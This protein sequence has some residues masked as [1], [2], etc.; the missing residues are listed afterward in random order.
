M[1]ASGSTI[2]VILPAFSFLQAATTLTNAL[3]QDEVSMGTTILAVR[4]KD[5]IVVGADTRTSVSGYVSNRYAAKLTFVLDGDVDNFVAPFRRS[6]SPSQPP[7][8]STTT[9]AKGVD[10]STCVICRS[11]SAADTQHLAS[12]IRTEIV[13][14]QLLYRIHGTVTHVAALLRNI[15]VNN[16]LSASIVCAGYDH[17]LGRGV[18]YSITQGGT[19]FEEKVWAAGGSGSTFIMGY[20]DSCYPK[21]KYYD[22]K[23]PPPPI[24]QSEEEALDFVCNAIGLA[25]DRDGSSGGFVRMYVI[26]RLGRRFVSRMPRTS[27][28]GENHN[29][30]IDNEGRIQSFAPAVSPP[31]L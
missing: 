24:L 3:R 9:S 31:P 20:L 1:R 28:E 6:S 11:G 10:A 2:A 16:E 18:I 14:R 23:A 27:E 26:N 21:D 5:G 12:V 30:Q 25:M 8:I 15:L 4:Y 7:R 22:N 17:I 13:S 29:Y 19:V